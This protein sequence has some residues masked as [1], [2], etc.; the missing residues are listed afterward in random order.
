M[1]N[2]KISVVM[3]NY[4]RGAFLPEAIESILN[5]TFR[6]F[7]F[8]IIDDGSVDNSWEI[9]QKYSEKDTRIRAFKNDKNYHIVYTRNRGISL[10]ETDLIAFL[11]SDDVAMPERLEI[12][13]EFMKNNLDCGVCGSNFEI[14]N[15]K[16]ELTG[17]KKFPEND[18][19]I[20]K[21]FFFFNP[22]GQNT[23]I[24]RK[25]CFDEV[26][27]Y[28]DEYRNAEDL[29]MWMRI[30]SKYALHNIQ[31]ELVKY[32]VHRDN[33]IFKNQKRMIR[34]TLKLRKKAVSGYGY[35]ITNKGRVAYF[36][37]WI[38]QFLPA[39]VVFYL[40]NFAKERI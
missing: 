36:A 24:I 1:N 8:I 13:L 37:T 40:F 35:K 4:N 32:R 12:Q 34:S 23:V 29:D 6:D 39:R 14:I 20:K 16:S 21:S 2:P 17:H 11:D 22:F 26:G 27:L 25:R 3:P 5:Q 7:E 10:S 31:K 38:M 28:N 30:G 9:I 18:D 19:D 15:E 33:S